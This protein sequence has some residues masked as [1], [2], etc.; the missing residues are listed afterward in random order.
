MSATY[1]HDSSSLHN[2]WGEVARATLLPPEADTL[3]A[4]EDC[5]FERFDISPEAE[6]IGVYLATLANPMNGEA[7]EKLEAVASD[8]G[9][10]AD[11]V[12]DAMDE[13]ALCGAVTFW[14]VY[15]RDGGDLF[16]HCEFEVDSDLYY[17]DDANK[18]ADWDG[19]I[20]FDGTE[21]LIDDDY[22]FDTGRA[23]FEVVPLAPKNKRRARIYEK[24]KGRCFYC[25]TAW[26]THLDH[27]H[28]QIRGGSHADE[29]M[30]GA[31]RSCNIRKNDRTVE[32]YRAYLAHK[33]RLPD[34][35]H[36]RFW[37]EKAN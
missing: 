18:P 27:M 30:I 6:F 23:S 24:T 2:M 17:G 4:A 16:L 14:R 32:E 3:P 20:G 29:N 5:F 12:R 11:R 34:I 10:D 9:F 15:Y 7:I 8:C 25:I 37:G 1:I 35:S 26:A 13:L 33:N 36:V 31:C 22:D 28:P 19:N 21:Y